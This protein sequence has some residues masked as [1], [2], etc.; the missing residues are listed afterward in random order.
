MDQDQER[1]YGVIDGWSEFNP[2]GFI[3]RNNNP[4]GRQVFVHISQCGQRLE[5]GT[6]VSYVLERHARGLRAADVELD[7]STPH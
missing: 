4:R 7:T 2:F 5:P 1:E 3:H 6:R